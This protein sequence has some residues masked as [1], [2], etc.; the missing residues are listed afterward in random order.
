MER[1]GGFVWE[2]S[3]SYSPRDSSD[4]LEFT[5]MVL[6][7]DP[8][9]RDVATQVLISR[10]SH[11]PERWGEYNATIESMKCLGWAQWSKEAEGS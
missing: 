5:C 3:G 7:R 8:A 9:G 10:V 4:A 6:S 2:V 11:I 1:F